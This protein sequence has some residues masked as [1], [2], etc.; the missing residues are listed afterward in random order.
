M[1]AAAGTRRRAITGS[2][3]APVSVVISATKNVKRPLQKRLRMERCWRM[4]R[5]LKLL[6][7]G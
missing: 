5:L 7:T 3:L 1:T 6:Q 4:G 2:V